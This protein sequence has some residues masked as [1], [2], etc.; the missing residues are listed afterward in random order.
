MQGNYGTK[1]NMISP[2]KGYDSQIDHTLSESPKKRH[3]ET[4]GILD[5]SNTMMANEIAVKPRKFYEDLSFIGK[6]Y[7]VWNQ[8]GIRRHYTISNCMKKNF[9]EEYLRLINEALDEK[10]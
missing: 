4:S 10:T 2:E 1:K 5:S 7:L 3:V 9:Y 6:H 8:K